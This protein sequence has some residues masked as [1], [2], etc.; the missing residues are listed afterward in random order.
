MSTCIGITRLLPAVDDQG[1]DDDCKEENADDAAHDH[2]GVRTINGAFLEGRRRR[3]GRRSR[4]VV[5]I[6][7][8]L[9]SHIN[10]IPP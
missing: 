10:K 3:G 2:A 6:I 4:S 7:V 5:H 1:V 9:Q 8:I